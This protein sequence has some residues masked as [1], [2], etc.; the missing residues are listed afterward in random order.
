MSGT[1]R[2]AAGSGRSGVRSSCPHV[3]RNTGTSAGA[4]PS[5]G[6]TDVI[7]SPTLAIRKVPPSFTRRASESVVADSA[8]AATA[9]AITRWRLRTRSSSL[10]TD[11]GQVE[12]RVHDH[13]A[14][15]RG[16][17]RRDDVLRV[18]DCDRG[19]PRQLEVEGSERAVARRPGWQ[20]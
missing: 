20:A 4:L 3:A 17:E 13:A 12:V 19:V 9:R 11:G 15:S 10:Q 2:Y 1:I 16:D 7:W 5:P 14:R 18:G 8:A 6:S